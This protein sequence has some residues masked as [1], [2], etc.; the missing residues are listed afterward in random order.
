MGVSTLYLTSAKENVVNKNDL[1]LSDKEHFESDMTILIT[2]ITPIVEG[3]ENDLKI[4]NL[5]NN[6]SI[7]LDAFRMNIASLSHGILS[8]TEKKYSN[9]N[10]MNGTFLVGIVSAYEG[11]IHDMFDT[12]CSEKDSI[13][14]AL[15]NVDKLSS[16]DKR[17]LRLR[18]A[19]TGKT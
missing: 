8:F 18:P 15:K 2:S 13:E 4:S 19:C 11:F 12:L 3:I 5:Y 9:D 6:L 7:N 10:F 17:Y 14:L 16:A 1:E